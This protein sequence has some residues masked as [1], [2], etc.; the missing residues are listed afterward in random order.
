ME[1]V[2]HFAI[3]EVF[4]KNIMKIFKKV[5][6]AEYFEKI[7]TSGTSYGSSFLMHFEKYLKIHVIKMLRAVQNIN[8]I[9]KLKVKDQKDIMQNIFPKMLI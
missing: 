9:D 3:R 5:V 7:I 6:H 4:D 1:C 2:C 8:N